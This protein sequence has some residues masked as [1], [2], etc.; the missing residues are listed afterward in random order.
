MLYELN[1]SGMLGIRDRLYDSTRLGASLLT[2]EAIRHPRPG[3]SPEGPINKDLVAAS[4]AFHE[5][6]TS[7]VTSTHSTGA[8]V[9]RCTRE[10]HIQT[11]PERHD[12]HRYKRVLHDP[13]R[14]VSPIH[15]SVEKT[16]PVNLED[17]DEEKRTKIEEK[18]RKRRAEIPAPTTNVVV[19]HLESSEA[20]AVVEFEEVLPSELAA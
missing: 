12:G 10:K 11:I 14:E 3:H 17:I 18:Q 5:L 4:V 6:F 9:T 15:L 2:D 7:I 8:L 20:G 1:P 19:L 16:P 13:N